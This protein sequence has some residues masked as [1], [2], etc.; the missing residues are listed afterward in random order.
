[1]N[2]MF[3]IL[4]RCLKWMFY[5]VAAIALLVIA[6][7]ILLPDETLNPDA[8]R[9]IGA[10]LT[11]PPEQNAYYALLGLRASPEL[12]AF[13]VGQQIVAAHTAA[14]QANGYW[15]EFQPDGYWGTTP[16]KAR[17]GPELFCKRSAETPNCLT[18]Y[19][20][21]HET[22]E[23][24]L[25]DLDPY[26]RRYRDLRR[27]QHFE[28]AMV[29][30]INMPFVNWAPLVHLVELVNA[31]IALDVIEP[32]RREAALNE[33]LGEILL[34]RKIGR[35]TNSLATRMMSASV[36]RKQ[37]R[38]ASELIAAHPETAIEH[39][40]VLTKITQPLDANDVSVK[41]TFDGE[42]RFVAKMTQHLE[43]APHVNNEEDDAWLGVPRTLNK[44]LFMGGYRTN[45]TVN[46]YHAHLRAVGDFYSKTGVDISAGA[47]KFD[48]AVN[49]Y[50]ERDPRT[51]FYNPVGKV[52][53]GVAVPQYSLYAYRLHDLAGYSRLV[54]LQRQLALNQTPPE[55]IA[56]FI[57]A[58]DANLADPY[59]GKP[60]TYDAA[61]QTISFATRG[62]ADVGEGA[63]KIN[64]AAQ[65]INAKP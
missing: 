64:A 63:V 13:Q 21:N 18:A 36:L 46:L 8:Q 2:K 55:K 48:G 45:A 65:M 5:G 28:E 52:L 41:R 53:A 43:S 60:M 3:S 30:T 58:S 4:N 39:R 6:C 34:W 1:M 14:I 40:E 19:R 31:K 7:W 51:W 26:L 38:L 25:R 44:L 32:T 54:E 15:T 33:L 16:M 12:D 24:E 11:V 23:A 56:E 42:F 49:H 59:T 37:Y 35:E 29:P 62:K 47:A 22:I 20:A 10:K 61:T 50:N 9:I 57:A 27:Y 17:S